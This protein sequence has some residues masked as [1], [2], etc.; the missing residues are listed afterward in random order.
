[1]THYTTID[2]ADT[3]FETRLNT[4][5]WDNA[6]DVEKTAALT[7]ATR[8]IDNLNFKG[9]KTDATQELEFPRG[10][11]TEVPDQIVWAT[12]EIALQLLNDVD[13]EYEIGSLRAETQSYEGVRESYNRGVMP[14][15]LLAGIL[16][17]KAWLYLK[18]Y[19][20]DGK[21]FTIS[22]GS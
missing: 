9:D 16:S 1:M 4:D 3:Y 19:L 12:C 6:Y 8:Q 15:Y 2:D 20:R 10:G 18:P 13:I 14:E 5:A 11:D 21:T 17:A 22:R 7:Q